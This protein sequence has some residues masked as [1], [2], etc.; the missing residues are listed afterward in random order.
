MRHAAED[1]QRLISE[2]LLEIA[3]QDLSLKDAQKIAKHL[4]NGK[5]WR[6]ALH[7]LDAAVFLDERKQ[8]PPNFNA[9]NLPELLERL[10]RRSWWLYP[11]QRKKYL[12][13]LEPEEPNHTAQGGSETKDIQM[14][15]VVKN[16]LGEN[17]GVLARSDLAQ[18][19][20]AMKLT[21]SARKYD[22]LIEQI[23]VQKFMVPLQK[24]GQDPRQVV[25]ELYYVSPILHKQTQFDLYLIMH[26]FI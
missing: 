5:A 16:L 20:K 7:I 9:T 11:F 17:D 4:G 21:L 23:G 22:D 14:A 19:L 26:N 12:K 1:V 13:L 18:R 24:R 10:K 25:P 15:T 3:D 2:E 8:L 6:G